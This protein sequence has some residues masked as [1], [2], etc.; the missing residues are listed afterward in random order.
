MTTEER[1]KILLERKVILEKMGE[2]CDDL[3]AHL[4]QKRGAKSSIELSRRTQFISLALQRGGDVIKTCSC[5]HGY[6][7]S[8]WMGLPL[9]GYQTSTV[10][11]GEMRNCSCKST[12]LVITKRPKQ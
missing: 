2:V 1:Q 11:A 7:P 10:V 6:R 8:E 4:D 12:L 5:G 3:A 9:V